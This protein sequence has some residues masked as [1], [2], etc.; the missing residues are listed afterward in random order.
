MY[1]QDVKTLT[2][3]DVEKAIEILDKE[4]PASAYKSVPGG[5]D[6]TDIDPNYMRQVLNEVFG[7]AGYG[8]GYTYDPD[9]VYTRTDV[10]TTRKGERTVVVAVVKYLSFWYTLLVDGEPKTGMIPATGASKNS[11]DAYAL[12][13]ALTN[14]IGNAVS[15]I[16]FQ[17]SVYLG[18]RSHRTVG[19]K[20]PARKSTKP[21][22][23]PKAKAAKPAPAPKAAKP[24]PV[25]AAPA[26]DIDDLDAVPDQPPA[27]APVPASASAGDYEIPIGKNG[28][29]DGKPGKK[30]SEVS[31]KAVEWYANEL[32][33][34]SEKAREL[35][36]NAKAY[37]AYLQQQQAA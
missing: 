26:D 29:K 4:L 15:N 30:L 33:P 25:T 9:H 24:A 23:A 36:E 5:A 2:G 10:E 3:L 32:K 19:K 21:K 16:G 28:P 8:W 22:P 37:L 14:A 27:P 20:P 31:Q 11:S 6:L 12:K 35:Q 34:A 18:K 13:G 1:V 7:L 17:I